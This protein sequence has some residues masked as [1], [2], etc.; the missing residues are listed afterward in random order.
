MTQTDGQKDAFETKAL[1]SLS[2]I[3][4]PELGVDIVN[5]G[6][7]YGISLSADA[8]CTITMT[9]TI[10]GCPL[11]DYLNRSIQEQLEEL[12]EVKKV[13]IDLVWEPAWSIDK[14]SREA[15]MDLG[16]H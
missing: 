13:K 12:P 3:I 2:K 16:I 4:D 9:L 8:C 7:I 6:L 14:M 5:L 10:M 1:A 11:S 15:K